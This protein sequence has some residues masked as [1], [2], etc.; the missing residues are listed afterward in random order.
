MN[1]NH[2]DAIECWKGLSHTQ[3]MELAMW[4]Q[5]LHECLHNEVREILT[6]DVVEEL[7]RS[8]QSLFWFHFYIL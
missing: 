8:G 4:Y 2:L 7:G 1:P 6:K 3:A 5:F